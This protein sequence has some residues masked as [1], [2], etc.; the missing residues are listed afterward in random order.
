MENSEKP[1]KKFY[2]QWWF[3]GLVVIVI[4][5][6][7]GVSG[8]NSAPQKVGENGNTTAGAQAPSNQPQVFNV[9]DQ[10]KQGD[11]VLSVT[12]VNKN[13]HSSNQFDTP[14][15]PSD[16]FVVVTVSMTNQGTGNL[17]VSGM[18]GFKLQ[19]ANGA[20]HDE[21][22]TAGIGLNKLDS[23]ASELAPGGS[24]TGDMVFEV[25]S[26]ATAKMI[27]HYQPL[28][29]FGQPVDIQLQ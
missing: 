1:K 22:I 2:K 6:I 5:I 23:A 3:W 13:W 29:S 7:A 19:D 16:V 18:W 17:S 12:K 24:V 21:A 28:F 4:L 26:N 8:S 9:G 15:N 27:L 14:Q 20:L 11:T 25:P 10:I